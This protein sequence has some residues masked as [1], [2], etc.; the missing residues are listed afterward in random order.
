M[1]WGKP[2]TRL[3]QIIC[4]GCPPSMQKAAVQGYVGEKVDISPRV[5]AMLEHMDGIDFLAF[6]PRGGSGMTLPLAQHLRTL[7]DALVT[8]AIHGLPQEATELQVARVRVDALR[9]A[10]DDGANMLHD[11]VME[12]FSTA[13][14]R[15]NRARLADLVKRDIEKFTLDLRRVS[16]VCGHTWAYPPAVGAFP[17]IPGPS[18]PRL[19]AYISSGGLINADVHQPTV[20]PTAA[21]GDREGEC[22]HWA[23][24][25]RCRFGTACVFTHDGPARAAGSGT[26]RRGSTRGGPADGSTVASTA[27]AGA[28][29]AK[30]A[31]GKSS[32]GVAGSGVVPVPAAA[33]PAAAAAA[34]AAV[35]AVAVAAAAEAAA[36]A[37]AAGDRAPGLP[38]VR[39]GPNLTNRGTGLA[40]L[41]GRGRS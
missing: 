5:H 32:T 36:A 30:K 17:A 38:R 14:L 13:N 37:A 6:V 31:R 9:R 8:I 20:A 19:R 7:G 11:H 10:F 40:P 28:A 3:W 18:W 33:A 21:T 23:K 22:R 34:A 16:D 4:G 24:N 2:T 12:H 29:P 15:A 35:A 41:W 25:G 26:K 39:P 1:S 27:A